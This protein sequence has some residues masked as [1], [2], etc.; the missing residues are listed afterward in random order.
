M[1]YSRLI[2]SVLIALVV[3][4]GLATSVGAAGFFV[5]SDN[6]SATISAGDTVDGGG[7]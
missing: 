4:L 7:R 5:G 1:R 6:G 3:S 2:D